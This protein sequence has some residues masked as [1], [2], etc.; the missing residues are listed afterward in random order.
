MHERM[1]AR[2]RTWALS[3]SRGPLFLCLAATQT[4]QVQA[5]RPFSDGLIVRAYAAAAVAAAVAVAKLQR[6]KFLVGFLSPSIAAPPAS[7]RRVGRLS[8]ESRAV[9]LFFR[10]GVKVVSGEGAREPGREKERKRKHSLANYRLN[11]TSGWRAVML[12]FLIRSRILVHAAGAA[13]PP[14]SF[15][16]LHNRLRAFFFSIAG[17]LI[18]RRRAF[19]C[20][21]TLT[22]T[23][24][25]L[26]VFYN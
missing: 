24:N 9:L 14:F 12:F 19:F 15:D 8:S 10:A 20:T 1:P 6:R 26:L 4:Y 21:H 18:G 5:A 25:L 17:L 3:R 23:I 13:Y 22:H 2:S 11:F 16:L 7:S